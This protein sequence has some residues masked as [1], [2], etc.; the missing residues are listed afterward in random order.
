MSDVYNDVALP[1]PDCKVVE[2]LAS[3]GRTVFLF[4]Q[5]QQDLQCDG[6]DYLDIE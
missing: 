1:Y 3:N 6:H 5:Q 4:N 2:M